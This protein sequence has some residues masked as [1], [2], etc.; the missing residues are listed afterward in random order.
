MSHN[1]LVYDEFP[2]A[3]NHTIKHDKEDAG[4]LTSVGWV[5]WLCLG[6]VAFIILVFVL[7]SVS[8]AQSNHLRSDFDSKM[9]QLQE[10]LE[11]Q[12]TNQQF[13]S[14]DTRVVGINSLRATQRRLCVMQSCYTKKGERGEQFELL[15]QSI[16]EIRQKEMK[17]F[18]YSH[19]N[20]SI[21]LSVAPQPKGTKKYLT[22]EYDV[23]SSFGYFSSI[24]L[25]ELEFNTFE[26]SLGAMRSITLCTNNPFLDVARCDASLTK[27][28]IL[29]LRGHENVPFV[30]ATPSEE[31]GEDD[32]VREEGAV[33]LEDK[34]KQREQVIGLRMYNIVF[35]QSE[36]EEKTT[37]TRGSVPPSSIVQNKTRHGAGSLVDANTY[38]EQRV[39]TLDLPQC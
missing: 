16:E 21:G 11:T 36:G 15:T 37:T 25:E 34:E 6:V 8:L 12:Q 29:A 4:V 24:R 14:A 32:S 22:I 2:S 20:V 1:Q 30:I 33:K 23:T 26:Q 10:R 13:I 27:R 18:Y 31:E 3:P 38:K 35:Y 5:T 17:D 39:L 9:Q 19:I 7:S 28:N